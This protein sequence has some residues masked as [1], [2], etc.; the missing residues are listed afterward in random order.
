M[1]SFGPTGISGMFALSAAAGVG[2]RACQRP[3]AAVRRSLSR[4]AG[5][6]VR[7]PRAHR[8]ESRAL[9][10]AAAGVPI[11]PMITDYLNAKQFWVPLCPPG[12]AP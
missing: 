4:R 1:K 10:A 2:V 6:G 3:R 12:R 5:S 11:R 7:R 9:H 8:A